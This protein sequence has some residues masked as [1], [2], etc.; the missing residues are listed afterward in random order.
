MHDHFDVDVEE[1]EAGVVL[2][3]RGELDLNTA[4]RFEEIG[5][6]A[7]PATA[8]AVVVDLRAV[9]FMDSTGL[10]A[11]VALHDRAC[12]LGHSFGIIKGPRQV[13]NLLELT[14]LAER[15]DVVDDPQETAS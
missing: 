3:A 4:A 5:Y 9:A 12:E 1:S 2:R 13:Q 11:L 14:H 7:M 15:L 8:G 10:R 6:E